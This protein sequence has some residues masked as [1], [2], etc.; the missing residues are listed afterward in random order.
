MDFL[1]TYLDKFRADAFLFERS[2]HVFQEVPGIP[3]FPRAPVECDNLHTQVLGHPL[4][5]RISHG[6]ER[7]YPSLSTIRIPDKS[8]ALMR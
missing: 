4:I 3:L 7:R 6:I 1:S 8:D 5:S 2:K